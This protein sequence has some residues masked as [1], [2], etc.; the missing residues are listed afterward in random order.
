M[1]GGEESSHP[2]EGDLRPP[3][4]IDQARPAVA[5]A[6]QT[7]LSW[8]I[9]LKVAAEALRARSDSM[10]IAKRAAATSREAKGS[11]A[12]Q[13]NNE[14]TSR[15]A[16]NNGSATI[17]SMAKWKRNEILSACGTSFTFVVDSE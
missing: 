14:S 10:P 1:E 7:S 4:R 16:K 5:K 2:T 9:P 15:G 8:S 13:P 11:I 6:D 3:S 12:I 17:M